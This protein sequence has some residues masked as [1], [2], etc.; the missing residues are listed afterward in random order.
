MVFTQ[1]HHFRPEGLMFLHLPLGGAVTVVL[2]RLYKE[3]HEYKFKLLPFSI[4]CIIILNMKRKLQGPV[5]P[6]FRLEM[7]LY[8]GPCS[9]PRI[10]G[11]R[12]WSV[13]RLPSEPIYL[14][15]WTSFPN[16]SY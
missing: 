9:Q 15:R 12:K 3:L 1:G 13:G 4:L 11:W 10:S 7:M 2:V 5:P 16:I 8:A 14:R 6:E